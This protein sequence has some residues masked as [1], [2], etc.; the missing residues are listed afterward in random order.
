VALDMMR[1]LKD[2]V[3]FVVAT[4]DPHDP[5]VGTTVEA[6]RDIT[7]YVYTAPEYLCHHLNFSFFSYLIER[8]RLQTLYIA[9]GATWIYDAIWA[10][11]TRYPQLRIANQ[12]YDYAV[13]W[14]E[15]YDQGLVSVI[16]AH[17]GVNQ[18]V[19]QAYVDKGVP[20][21]KVYLIHHGVDTAEYAPIRYNS[22]MC[23]ALKEKFGLPQDKQIISF[24]SRLHPQKRPLDFVELA[25][26]C[27]LDPSLHFFMVSEGPLGVQVDETISRTNLT[28]ITHRGFYQPSS[29]LFAVSDLVVL[30]SEYEGMPLVILEAQ[31][32]GKPVV[33]TNVGNT[34]E[35]LNTTQG[36][37][38]ISE[39]GNVSALRVGVKKLLEHPPDARVMREAVINH[40]GL[41]KIA[42]QYYQALLG[43]PYA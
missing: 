14:I 33:V 27:S 22:E 10:I 9:S 30:P 3:R 17:I 18:K 6:F 12:V 16:D 35:V 31:A 8:F 24:L 23:L 20:P 1:C 5:R 28:N 42:Q 29:D 37:I 34:Q 38:V 21:E 26:Q 36:G 43:I 4:V 25:R 40:Y 19:C 11:K 7:P 15:R 13:G 2:K 32:M 41:E 39:I